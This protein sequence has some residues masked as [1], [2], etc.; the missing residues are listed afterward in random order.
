MVWPV[1]AS[2]EA[3]HFLWPA[4]RNLRLP[5]RHQRTNENNH[6]STHHNLHS[7]REYPS[8]LKTLPTLLRLL[9]SAPTRREAMPPSNS[10]VP[11]LLQS[12]LLPTR[13]LLGSLRLRLHRWVRMPSRQMIPSR[14]HWPRLWK[15][16]TFLIDSTRTLDIARVIEHH[17]CLTLGHRMNPHTLALL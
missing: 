7:A 4:L 9:C 10:S 11:C 5:S 13:P 8:H 15:P 3:S 12:G 2:C 16:T 14:T 17:L 6:K 1:E